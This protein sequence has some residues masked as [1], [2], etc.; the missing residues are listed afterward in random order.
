MSTAKCTVRIR[1]RQVQDLLDRWRTITYD[2]RTIR[3]TS[4]RAEMT[5]QTDIV[6]N[7]SQLCGNQDLFWFEGIETVFNG[8]FDIS[9]LHVQRF[10]YWAQEH[11]RAL[12][13]V[14]QARNEHE[15]DLEV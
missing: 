5:I 11:M 14:V 7:G 9:S 2:M 15:P 6:I 4:I 10:M 12:T 13:I 3:L 1:L 8:S